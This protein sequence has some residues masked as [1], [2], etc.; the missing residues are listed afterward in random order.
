LAEQHFESA[1]AIIEQTRSELLKPEW[2]ISYL[3]RLINFYQVYVDA[4]CRRGEWEKAL[5]IADS[6]R[7]RVL[8]E[9]TTGAVSKRTPVAR[10][11]EAG[12]R[13]GQV[14]FYWLAP[15]RSYAWVLSREGVHGAELAPAASIEKQVKAYSATIDD[16][17]VDPL[18]SELPAASELGRLVIKPIARWLAPEVP[19]VVVP[20]GALNN[21]NLETLPV[22]RDRPHYWIEDVSIRIAPSISALASGEPDKGAVPP[23]L[24]LIGNP[25]PP[26][27][28]LPPLRS[29]A[30]E[31]KSVSGQFAGE[32][33]SE[34]SGGQATPKA[35]LDS[36]PERFSVIHFTAHSLANV[37]SPLDSAVVLSPS[38]GEYK[39]YARDILQ[40]PI[41]AELV[42]ISACRGAGARAYTG[43]G[44]VGFAWAFLRAGAR[45]V[46][47]GLW[48]VN[49][50]STARLMGRLYQELKSNPPAG[51]LRQAKISLLHAG[52]PW[53]R[54]YYWG[55]FQ[56]YSVSP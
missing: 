29:A 20:D 18:A 38:A 28:S 30:L 55:A 45:N 47:A 12:I 32:S 6:S 23:S 56:L 4:L 19:I 17:M 48:D 9:R 13:S 44:M 40:H 33:N 21:I 41:H 10:L 7:A 3:A 51:A 1:L 11:K 25:A 52:P 31:L 15:E 39:L 14:V 26:D 43:E 50:D 22:Y 34:Y 46:I 35:Y 2:R 49:D 16:T 37:E 36:R 53:S 42:T 24:L 27:K 8:A 5:E 54:P